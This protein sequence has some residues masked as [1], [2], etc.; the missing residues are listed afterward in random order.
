MGPELMWM[1]TMWHILGT[2]FFFYVG[3]QGLKKKTVGFFILALF[4]FFI[5][6]I[7]MISI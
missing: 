5:G 2:V 3:V 4:C 1:K 7:S 6:I